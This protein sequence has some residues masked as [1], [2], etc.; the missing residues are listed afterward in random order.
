MLE[1]QGR[2]DLDADRYDSALATLRR[3]AE[4]YQS[5]G[6]AEGRARALRLAADVCALQNRTGEAIDLYRSLLSLY[7]QTGNLNKKATV[8]NNLGLQE[9]TADQCTNRGYIHVQKGEGAN[10]L[11]WYQRALDLYTAC[12][13]S[14][15]AQLTRQ[16]VEQLGNLEGGSGEESNR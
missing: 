16:N 13:S 9:N 3:A 8:M 4:A 10:A 12:G 2:K 15:K 11:K 14:L 5:S 7:D 1:Q 6:D